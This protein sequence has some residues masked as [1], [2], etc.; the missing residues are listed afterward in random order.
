MLVIPIALMVFMTVANRGYA[1]S[2]SRNP[3]LIGVM[4]GSEA[5]GA[6]WIRKIINFDH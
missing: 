3:W 5:L 1:D 6:V 4:L 2:L